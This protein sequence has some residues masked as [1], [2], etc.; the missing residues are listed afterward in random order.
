[1]DIASRWKN[2]S[3]FLI[4]SRTTSPTVDNMHTHTHIHSHPLRCSST[5]IMYQEISH[6]AFSSPS[7]VDGYTCSVR[8]AW[9]LNESAKFHVVNTYF[10]NGTHRAIISIRRQI[11]GNRMPNG[12]HHTILRYRLAFVFQRLYYWLATK[13]FA[14]KFPHQECDRKV[15]NR[16]NFR[17]FF[18][19]VVFVV[20]IHYIEA[21][22]I[23]LDKE[24]Y[25][26]HTDAR[27]DLKVRINVIVI[28]NFVPS[29]LIFNEYFLFA[30]GIFSTLSSICFFLLT[31]LCLG[32]DFE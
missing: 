30:S 15:G 17:R 9:V 16:A 10:T 20:I 22:W 13:Y 14:K 8:W 2:S 24:A 31:G 19:V 4:A 29:S 26:I 5:F 23:Y 28:I 11:S 6:K 25:I 27:I 21:I 1:M 3:D 18:V 32:N 7:L 12:I